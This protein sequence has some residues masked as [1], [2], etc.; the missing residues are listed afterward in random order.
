MLAVIGH[1]GMN[2]KKYLED[3][4]TFSAV[5]T[6]DNCIVIVQITMCVT[7]MLTLF[8]YLFLFT[9]RDMLTKVILTQHV[10]KD[11][12]LICTITHKGKRITIGVYRAYVVLHRIIGCITFHQIMRVTLRNEYYTTPLG[13]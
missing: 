4:V 1:Q 13:E 3:F 7:A 2:R 12:I 5:F 11:A 6:F 9:M 10:N 8:L